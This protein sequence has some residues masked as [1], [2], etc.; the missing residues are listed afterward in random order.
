MLRP[1]GE[2]F[3]AKRSSQSVRFRWTQRDRIEGGRGAF[4]ASEIRT[5]S[6]VTGRGQS[7]RFRNGLIVLSASVAAGLA[8]LAGYWSGLLSDTSSVTVT[9][10][11]PQA[12]PTGALSGADLGRCR[13]LTFDND[14]QFVQDNVPCDGSVRDARGQPLPMGTIHR[15][16]AIRKSF[17]GL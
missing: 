13:R 3:A 16:D 7:R 8:V 9:Q 6:S 11:V 12:L 5:K 10:P 15:L 17:P 2:A 1:Y 4:I 14:G